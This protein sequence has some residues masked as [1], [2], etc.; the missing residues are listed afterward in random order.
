MADT[1]QEITEALQTDAA[2][3]INGITISQSIFIMW[4]VMAALIIF[5]LVVTR[6]LSADNP[7]KMQCLLEM[8]YLKFHGFFG[9]LVGE[10]GKRYIPYL[11]FMLFFIGAMNLFPI[12]GVKPPTKDINVTIACAVVTIVLV[13]VASIQQRG[14]GGWLKSFTHPVVIVTPINILELIIKPLSL[15]LRLFGNM[16][17][18]FAIMKLLEYVVPIVVPA[19]AMLYFDFFDGILQA[20]IFAFLSAMY[21]G[22]AVE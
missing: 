16:I 20:F 15:C 21:I 2:F 1:G 13:Q 10:K 6:N 11:T 14:A 12:F 19:F 4:I 3:I 7:G 9:G 22:E 8:A 5:M 17:G 18:A